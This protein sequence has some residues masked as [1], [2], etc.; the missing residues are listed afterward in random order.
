MM[1]M[2]F[3]DVTVKGTHQD[4][5][6]KV[7]LYKGAR[8]GDELTARRILLERFLKDRF[9]VVRIDRVPERCL[10]IGRDRE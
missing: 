1:R 8:A 5:P 3:F 6:R 9:Q 2:D 10:R 4:I 7:V